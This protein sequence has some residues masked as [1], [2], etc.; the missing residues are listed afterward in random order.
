MGR[1]QGYAEFFDGYGESLI[2]YNHRITRVGIGPPY[3]HTFIGWFAVFPTISANR[4]LDTPTGFDPTSQLR[5]WVNKIE[6]PEDTSF[7]KHQYDPFCNYVLNRWLTA[8][9]VSLLT[10]KQKKRLCRFS[11]RSVLA[12]A[13]S[14]LQAM[15]LQRF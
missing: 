2:D 5:Y 12:L 8:A 7:Q 14:V 13:M 1:L 9:R 6:D 15:Q 3:G 10:S 11:S 4:A